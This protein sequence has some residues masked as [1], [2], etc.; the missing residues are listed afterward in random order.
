RR[1]NRA[2]FG[3]EG[4]GLELILVYNPV[5]ASLPPSQ[6]TLESD[7][8]RELSAHL[9]LRFTR[10]VTI[11][12]QPIHRF[13]E[14]LERQGK[15]QGY[16][17]LLES[18]F[19]AATLPSLM[20]RNQVSLRW[21]GALFDCDFNLVIDLPL[22]GPDGRTLTLEDLCPGPGEHGEASFLEHLPVTTASHCFACTAG[23]GSSCGGSL[24]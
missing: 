14:G 11:T 22:R 9:G 17:E 1:L 21:D 16:Q 3:A 12:N 6:K 19:N 8:R 5:G 24:A 10:L 2:G 4:T 20:C 15:L 7:Y 18:N 13:R 23:A